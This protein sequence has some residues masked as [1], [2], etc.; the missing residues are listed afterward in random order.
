VKLRVALA[1]AWHCSPADLRHITLIE[2][3]AMIQLL[4]YVSTT[5]DEAGKG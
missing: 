4:E 3:Q 5:T 2:A 1:Y